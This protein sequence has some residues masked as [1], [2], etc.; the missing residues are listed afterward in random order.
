MLMSLV[1]NT[2]GA[3]EGKTSILEENLSEG[4]SQTDF[5]CLLKTTF[6]LKYIRINNSLLKG[7]VNLQATVW[8][9]IFRGTNVHDVP[10]NQ[11]GSLRGI[12]NLEHII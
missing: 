2:E 3:M 7:L 10:H 12:L 6:K 9:L 8:F 1:E 11:R 4:I 5:R